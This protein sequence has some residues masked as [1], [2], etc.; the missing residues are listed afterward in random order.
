[1]SKERPIIEEEPK[2]DDKIIPIDKH[3]TGNT[4]VLDA[5]EPGDDIL[6]AGEDTPLIKI[7]AVFGED[8]YIEPEEEEEYFD[9]NKDE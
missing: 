7:P 1:M 8:G 6:T 9:P 4:P 5:E 2:E 3:F